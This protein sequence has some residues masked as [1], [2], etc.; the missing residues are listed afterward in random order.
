QR[1]GV[2]HCR[3]SGEEEHDAVNGDEIAGGRRELMK[4]QSTRRGAVASPQ[5]D[6]GA[7]ERRSKEEE[8]PVD[9]GQGKRGTTPVVGAVHQGRAVD[10][11][12]PLPQATAPE[13]LIVSREEEP[14]VVVLEGPRSLKVLCA[15]EGFDQSRPRLGSVC[16]P[17]SVAVPSIEGAE[18]YSII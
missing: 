12:A 1:L 13:D 17:E 10:G 8:P 16:L 4:A 5:I 14:P 15:A 7:A 11:C 18:E 3:L 9:V 6:E 2:A